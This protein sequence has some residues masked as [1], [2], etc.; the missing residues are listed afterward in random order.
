MT[1]GFSLFQGDF[2][3]LRL[4]FICLKCDVC[5]YVKGTVGAVAVH[6]GGRMSNIEGIRAW[7]EDRCQR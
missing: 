4:V 2:S 3:I 5:G 7:K 1:P 6:S